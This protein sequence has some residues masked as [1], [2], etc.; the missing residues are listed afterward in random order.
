MQDV[1]AGEIIGPGDFRL[2]RFFFPALLTHYGGALLPQLH[3]GIGVDAVVDAAMTGDV[4]ASH[5][6]VSGVDD[7]ITAQSGNVSLPEIYPLCYGHQICEISN[8]LLNQLFSEI[9]VL[10][11]KEILAGWARNA[12]IHQGAEK[13]FLFCGICRNRHSLILGL[14]SK[15]FLYQICST[16]CVGHIILAFLLPGQDKQYGSCRSADNVPAGFDKAFPGQCTAGDNVRRS[17]RSQYR[18]CQALQAKA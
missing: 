10:R 18:F 16:I 2:S 4:T 17:C 3:P 5:S 7:G 9:F 1:L 13:P 15:Q 12:D 14:F 6:T 11:C 8:T